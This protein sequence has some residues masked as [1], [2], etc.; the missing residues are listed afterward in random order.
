MRGAGCDGL[1]DQRAGCVLAAI[2]FESAGATTM[3]SY[4]WVTKFSTASTCEAKSRS[5]FMPTA[6]KSNLSLFSAA[7]LSAP[8]FICL[9]NSFDKDFMIRPTFGFSAAKADDTLQD[10]ASSKVPARPNFNAA[11]R[12]ALIMTGSRI[13]LDTFSSR[14]A[15]GS[16]PSELP[17]AMNRFQ[18][19][20]GNTPL[21]IVKRPK[22]SKDVVIIAMFDVC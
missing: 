1:L 6:L 2:A 10:S 16:A 9:K 15:Q 13:E 19:Q 22:V 20:R 4:F 12:G 14:T 3:I 7:Y 17:A 5:S 18:R 11:R 8:A 21:R